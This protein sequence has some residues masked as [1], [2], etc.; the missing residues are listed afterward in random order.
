MNVSFRNCSLVLLLLTIQY[1]IWFA[2]DGYHLTRELNDEVHL[3]SRQYERMRHL[4]ES[5]YKNKNKTAEQE[6]LEEQAR[7]MYHYVRPGERFISFAAPIFPSA[8]PSLG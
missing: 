4:V 5:K 6:L 1:Q 7:E 3:L 8:T 2:H